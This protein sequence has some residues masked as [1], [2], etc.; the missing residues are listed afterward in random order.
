MLTRNPPRHRAPRRRTGAFARARAL[1]A[2]ALVLGVGATATLAAW[3][4]EE[5]ATTTITAGSFGLESQVSGG[6]WADHG[7]G[8]AAVLPLNATGLYPG[9]SRA[10]WIQ[11]RTKS[12]S[13]PGSVALSGVTVT[14][15]PTADPNLSLAAGIDVRIGAVP[16]TANC[17]PGW[18]GGSTASGLGTLPAGVGPEALAGNGGSIVTF[19]VVVTLRSNAA[20]AAQ[21]ASL[22]PEWAF[23]GSTPA[24]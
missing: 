10:A 2:G 13:V 1:L 7:A 20:N 17:V 22:T 5:H 4:D 12:G 24:S 21:G 23:T 6:G 14:P 3:T 16:G 15:A 18:T 19:C 11:I 8:S 9:Q